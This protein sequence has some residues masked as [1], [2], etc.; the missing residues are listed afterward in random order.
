[1][2]NWLLLVAKGQRRPLYPAK[3][4]ANAIVEITRKLDDAP[5]FRAVDRP[6]LE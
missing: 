6:I 4:I 5:T 2:R 1:M 3:P